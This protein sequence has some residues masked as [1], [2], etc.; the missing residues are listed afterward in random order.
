MRL[1]SKKLDRLRMQ[2]KQFLQNI[3]ID[4]VL[5]ILLILIVNLIA[6]INVECCIIVFLV[7]PV[8]VSSY[9]IYCAKKS[10]RTHFFT[11]FAITSGL[12]LLGL[13]EFFVPLL[14][15]LPQENFIFISLIFISVSCFFKVRMRSFP[16]TL[17]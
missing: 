8:M 10:A 3:K 15:L 1:N 14:E 9:Y 2:L 17:N 5:P 6:F 12:Y 16:E 4:S 11:V 7:L 13:F